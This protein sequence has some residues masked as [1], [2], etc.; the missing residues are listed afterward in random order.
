MKNRSYLIKVK[1][2]I[3]TFFLDVVLYGKKDEL[4]RKMQDMN[5]IL[6][7]GIHE[8]IFFEPFE[9]VREDSVDFPDYTI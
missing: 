1:A 4:Y 7:L 9:L 6:N 3:M 2:D 5:F 8:S